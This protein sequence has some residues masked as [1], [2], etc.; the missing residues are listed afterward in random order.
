MRIADVI[1]AAFYLFVAVVAVFVVEETFQLDER[2]STLRWVV[3]PFQTVMVIAFGLG[4]LRHVL[5]VIYPTLRPDDSA[6][7]GEEFYDDDDEEGTF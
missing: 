2:T 4:A 3:W 6:Q 5:Y 7:E 1:T